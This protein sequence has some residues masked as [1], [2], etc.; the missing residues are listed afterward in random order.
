MPTKAEIQEELD[1]RGI[2]YRKSDTKDELKALLDEGS[3]A[4]SE[5]NEEES[6]VSAD[7][8]NS[9]PEEDTPEG[10]EIR[11]GVVVSTEESRK[12]SEEE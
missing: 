9:S 12:A 3:D 8:E 2:E 5:A 10:D 4:S 1:A 7:A 11:D 6:E